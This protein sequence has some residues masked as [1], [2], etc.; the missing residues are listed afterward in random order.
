MTTLGEMGPTRTNHPFKRAKPLPFTRQEPAA[1]EI[2]LRKGG[3]WEGTLYLC[4][5]DR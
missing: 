1:R 2:R 3:E 4:E 5:W